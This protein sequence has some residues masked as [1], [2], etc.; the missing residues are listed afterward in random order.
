MIFVPRD[1]EG[2]PENMM[3]VP[4]DMA[5]SLVDVTGVWECGEGNPGYMEGVP[6]DIMGFLANMEGSL[7]NESGPW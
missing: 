5:G 7:G 6:G 4:G 2:V 1:M 3:C